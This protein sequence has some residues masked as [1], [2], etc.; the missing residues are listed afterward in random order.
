MK[1]M[2]RMLVTL[3]ACSTMSLAL[4]ASAQ[5]AGSITGG[6][7]LLQ[8]AA[9]P[10]A[11]KAPKPVLYH[12]TAYNTAFE[13]GNETTLDLYNKTKTFTVEGFCDVGTFTKVGKA[14]TFSD[15]CTGET[16]DLEKVKKVKNTFFGP[17]Y[18][19]LDELDAYIEM[20]KE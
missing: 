18:N 14:L 19:V 7:A 10:A 16:W 12:L 9:V 1:T 8:S 5:A 4:V 13:R 20:V 6:P 11:K 3:A 17:A 2:K 15:E